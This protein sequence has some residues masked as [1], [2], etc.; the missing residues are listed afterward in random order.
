MEFDIAIIGGGPAGY[1]AAERAAENGLKTILFEK[2]RIGG[3]CLNV[4]C[5]PT[6]TL[7]YSAKIL[8]YIRHADKYGI[9]P[10]ADPSFDLAK[11][12][13]RKNKTVHKLTAGVKMRLTANGVTIRPL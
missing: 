8:D 12:M 1:T 5:I 4:G 10:G 13:A 2:N 6:K 9:Q 7:L 11:I 3:V